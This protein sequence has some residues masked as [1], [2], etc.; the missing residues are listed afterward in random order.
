MHHNQVR[1]IRRHL[2]FRHHQASVARLKLDA[3]VAN[4]QPHNKSKRVAQPVKDIPTLY[5]MAGS[6]PFRGSELQLRHKARPHSRVIP[7]PLAP[8]ASGV[9]DLLFSSALG[10]RSFSSDIKPATKMRFSA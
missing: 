1:A 4:A 7:N 6:E 8:F 9:R 10:G 2:P 3:V 5:E